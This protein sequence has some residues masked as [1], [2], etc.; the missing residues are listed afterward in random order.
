M[1]P[2][3]CSLHWIFKHHLCLIFFQTWFK[4][5]PRGKVAGSAWSDLHLI[6]RAPHQL[7]TVGQCGMYIVNVCTYWKWCR[8]SS[9]IDSPSGEPVMH[10]WNPVV[11]KGLQ[12]SQSEAAF[13]FQ[14]G[15]HIMPRFALNTVSE[16]PQHSLCGFHQT[17]CYFSSVDEC[18]HPQR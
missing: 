1:E 9:L 11:L 16:I 17:A 10:F 6:L 4:T 12:A 13:F 3:S 14:V 5:L 8:A 18:T 2:A 7:Y 15:K